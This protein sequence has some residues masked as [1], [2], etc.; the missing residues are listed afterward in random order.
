[1]SNLTKKLSNTL[2]DNL[3]NLPNLPNLSNVNEQMTNMKNMA[4][5][6]TMKNMTNV[7]ENVVEKTKT[8]D[9]RKIFTYIILACIVLYFI[10]SLYKRYFNKNKYLDTV[11][12]NPLSY[13]LWTEM[14]VS[15]LGSYI[16][17]TAKVS[18]P[19][20]DNI[21]NYGLLVKVNNW[22]HGSS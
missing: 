17:D 8:T 20:T 5:M 18:I 13:S 22:T 2:S 3:P 19:D 14:P 12:K 21:I 1:M 10:Y 11:L 7:L 16:T 15:T 6:A 9:K 4:N